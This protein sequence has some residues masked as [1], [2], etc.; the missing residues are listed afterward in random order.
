MASSSNSPSQIISLPKGGAQ[1]GLGEKFSRALHTGT[2]NFTVPIALPPGRNGFQPQLNLVY[3]TGNGNGPF[4][5]CSSLSI[6]DITRRTSKGLPRYHD[7]DKDLKKRDTFILSGTEDL[8]PI[9][10][11]SLDP[12]KATRYRPRTEGLFARIV[13]HHN[14]AAHR[15]FLEVSSKDGLVSC[16]GTN[17]ADQQHTIAPFDVRSLRPRCQ[18]ETEGRRSRLTVLLEAR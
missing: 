15:N 16:Y 3:S 10:D 5:L 9:S 18:T 7:Y 2:R 8:I 17:P 13:H 6:P 12:S 4:G 11:S 1:R 14:A